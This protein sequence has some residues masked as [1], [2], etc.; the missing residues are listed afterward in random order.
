VKKKI[1]ALSIFMIVAMIITAVGCGNNSKNTSSSSDSSSSS[2]DSSKKEPTKIT[3]W[4]LW[5][6]S[7]AES[8]QKVIDEFNDTHENIQVEVLSGTT[9]EK[10]L[11]AITGGNPPDVGYLIDYRISKLASV[12]ALAELDPYIEKYGM[13]SKNV[14]PQMW[15]LGNY[16]GK[17]YG[18]PY[19]MDSYMLYYN[20][21]LF[22]EA[23]ITEPPKTMGEL[24]EYAKK[25]TKKDSNGDYSQIGYVSDYPW[26]DQLNLAY[27][28]GADFY[29]F[30]NDKITCDSQSNIDSLKFKIT[31]Y[32]DPYEPE[33]VNKF[34][35][36]FGKYMSPNHPFFQKQLAMDIEGQ[37]FTT[38]IKL[39]AP[40]I[41]Y[42]IIPIPYPDG[43]PELVNG[44]QIQGGMLYVPKN[45][46]HKEEAF[47]FIN[48]LK[49]DDAYIKFC[50]SK[51]SI[52]TNYSALNNPKFLEEVPELK[53]FVDIIN[54]GNAKAFVPIPFAKEYCDELKLQEE[55]IYNFEI[56][57]EEGMKNVI[58]KIQPLADE[59][60]KN[61]KK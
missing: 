31:S 26:L 43:K 46:K 10:Q 20:K 32:Q 56:T 40:D 13:D 42:G 17:Q 59:W 38:F 33:K 27:V 57:P 35:S 29:D 22:K 4:H 36:G 50:A 15:K 21:D 3:F 60:V 7:E 6:G 52:P 14:V 47:E 25:L 12:G 23:G 24:Q 44:G 1:K 61:R 30:E 54:G 28:F 55:K 48:Y 51:G 41:N 18:V 37:W 39:Y 53:P 34:K 16:G 11:T 45:S 49:S 5:A 2:S 19:T 8:L 58:E 9:T